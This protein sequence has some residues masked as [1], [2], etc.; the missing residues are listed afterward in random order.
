[1]GCN[2][3]IRIADQLPC[4]G[5]FMADFGIMIRRFLIP[6]QNRD[7]VEELMNP[8][9]ETMTRRKTLY[10]LVSEIALIGQTNHN[11]NGPAPARDPRFR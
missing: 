6:G 5:Q 9:M 1:M 2:H 10:P 11:V 3:H 7:D 4:V 8:C